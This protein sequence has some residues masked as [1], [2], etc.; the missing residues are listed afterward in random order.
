MSAIEDD[1]KVDADVATTYL[2]DLHHSDYRC[3][4]QELGLFGN[5]NS[6]GLTIRYFANN[7]TFIKMDG[8]DSSWERAVVESKYGLAD[9]NDFFIGSKIIVFGRHLTICSCPFEVCREIE[10]IGKSLRERQAWLRSKIESVGAVPMVPDKSTNRA[11]TQLRYTNTGK[12]D[13]R[14]LTIDNN[15][16]IEQMCSV[17]LAHLVAK[18]P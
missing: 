6:F 15:R 13:L 9:R 11:S 5:V 14:R 12:S 1:F 17:G 2:K 4:W 8:V 7:D 10:V 16:L 18:A 3:E